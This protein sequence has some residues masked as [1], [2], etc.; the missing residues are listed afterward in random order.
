MNKKIFLIRHGETIYNARGIYLGWTAVPISQK[1]RNQVLN[2]KRRLKKENIRSIYSSPL[3][4]AYQTAEIIAGGKNITIV[5]ALKDHRISQ[6]FEGLYESEIRKKY[7][8]FE[9]VLR[10][11]HFKIKDGEAITQLYKR[12]STWFDALRKTSRV[13]TL[14][15]THEIIINLILISLWEINIDSEAA[16]KIIRSQRVRHDRL[17]I[18]EESKRFGYYLSLNSF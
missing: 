16:L 6:S 9:K 17:N 13:N 7:P 10:D 18:I 8:E 14:I 1:G 3:K 11:V 12:V 15:I 4:R 2:L 5:D